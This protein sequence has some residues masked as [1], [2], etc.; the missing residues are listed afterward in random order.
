MKAARWAAAAVASAV[1]AV[2]LQGCDLPHVDGY[3]AIGDMDVATH[4]VPVWRTMRDYYSTS[5]YRD[6]ETSRPA[7]NSCENPRLNLANV[8]GGRGKC[9]PF[10]KRNL[11]TPVFFCKCDRAYAGLECKYRRKRQTVA[12]VLSLF[13]G[14]LGLDELYLGFIELAMVKCLLTL[15]GSLVGLTHSP[16]LGVGI[17]VVP[18][19]ADVV[20][21]GLG[22][23]KTKESFRIEPDLL[24][25]AF[26]LITVLYVC[27]LAVALA[28]SSIYNVV[29]AR[30]R[31]YDE[32]LCYGSAKV[33]T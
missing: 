3:L 23:V 33:L 32:M 15:A 20:R 26:A 24:R 9:E 18:W 1:V 8:C 10:D 16:A 4:S 21:I 25:P 22:P 12:W 31:H 5:Y 6:P 27:I 14:P 30:R 2:T 13:F 19:L 7:F 11:K 28:V 17:I 29:L